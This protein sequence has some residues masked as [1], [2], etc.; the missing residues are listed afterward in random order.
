MT[1]FNGIC[2]TEQEKTNFYQIEIPF[3]DICLS[4]KHPNSQE[5]SPCTCERKEVAS[6]ISRS[7]NS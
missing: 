3:S 4:S 2:L 7:P 6:R 1:F 5:T